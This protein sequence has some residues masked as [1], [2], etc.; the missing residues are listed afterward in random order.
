VNVSSFLTKFDHFVRNK[1]TH[2]TRKIEERVVECQYA[3]VRKA[4]IKAYNSQ[5]PDTV[6][7][8]NDCRVTPGFMEAVKKGKSKI[9]FYLGDNPFHLGRRKYF[10]RILEYADLI[11]VADSRQK[12]ELKNV[13]D[14]K[15]RIEFLPIGTNTNIYKKVTPSEEDLRKYKCDIL[16]IGRSY[17]ENHSWSYKRAKTLNA[18]CDF[19]SK[20]FGDGWQPYFEIFPNFQ[21]RCTVANLFDHEV[22]I[23]NNCAKIYPVET[24]PGVYHGVHTRVFDCAASGIFVLAEYREDIYRLF[25][26]DEIITYTTLKD[27]REKV[28]YYLKNENERIEMAAR[29]RRKVVTEHD[30]N[31]CVAKIF[32][33]L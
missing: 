2:L 21:K 5:K 28:A 20:F 16:F 1:S 32:D 10:M 7:I 24:N 29:L 30:S 22:N 9:V 11:L 33:L 4:L 25:H 13:F 14:D 15:I 6:V 19:D 27:L 26:K 12:T 8:Y 17:Y 23:A 31:I 3:K 18:L